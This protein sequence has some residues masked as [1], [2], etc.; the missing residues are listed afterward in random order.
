MGEG[1]FYLFG[2]D[3]KIN[4]GLLAMEN[5]IVAEPIVTIWL[6]ENMPWAN[7]FKKEWF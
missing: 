1:V 6:I 2:S 4:V 5:W 3:A 7:S